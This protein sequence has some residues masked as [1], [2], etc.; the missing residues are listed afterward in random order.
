MI[1][2]EACGLL[3][4]LGTP[5]E[6]NVSDLGGLLHFL[7]IKPYCYDDWFARYQDK[8]RYSKIHV[9]KNSVLTLN[10]FE[11]LHTIMLRR[12]KEGIIKQRKQVVILPVMMSPTERSISTY[13]ESVYK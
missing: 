1:I 9:Y 3:L 11:M 8:R 12:H 6:N 13:I 7:R 2:L 4:Y 10:R 5:V